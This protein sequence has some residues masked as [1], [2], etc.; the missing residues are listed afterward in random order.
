M[1]YFVADCSH[2]GIYFTFHLVFRGTL[3]ISVLIV[4][5]NFCAASTTLITVG[6]LGMM[7]LMS[8]AME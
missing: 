8:S 1:Q 4:G 6:A 3:G 7:G 5:G 2:V